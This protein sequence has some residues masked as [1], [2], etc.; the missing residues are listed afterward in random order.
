MIRTTSGIQKIA[1]TVGA[2]FT[3]A[4][5]APFAASAQTHHSIFHRHPTA[6]GAVAGVAAYRAAKHTG[7][8][9]TASGRH[10]NFMQRH[11]VATGV[12]AAVLAHRY[13]KH[14]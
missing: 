12:G 10:R 5:I 1:L 3:M 13:A 7:H 11:P 8:R 4:G 14:H 9:R 6:T 2:A